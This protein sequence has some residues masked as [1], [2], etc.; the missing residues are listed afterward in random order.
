[1]AKKLVDVEG[2]GPAYAAKLEAAGVKTQ[3]ELLTLGADAKGREALAAKTGISQKLVLTWVNRADL[4]RV[5]G[6]GGQ[7]AE[8]LE[9][10]GVDSVPE[11]AQRN[12][13]NLHEAMGKIN[14]EKHAVRQVPSLKQVE[15]WV[16]QAKGL[17]RVVNH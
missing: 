17:P 8:L 4:A 16:Q 14:A 9:L 7:Y 1:M 6:I 2:I 11:L 12:A 3:E 13:A 15:D 5:T 10:A